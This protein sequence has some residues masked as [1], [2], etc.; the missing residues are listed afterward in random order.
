ML[1]EWCFKTCDSSTLF[2]FSQYFCK[3]APIQMSCCL[4]FFL[5]NFS[6]LLL[7]E[8]ANSWNDLN[9]R[10][11]GGWTCFVMFPVF[12]LIDLYPNYFFLSSS[13][14]F[15]LVRLHQL[16]IT[17]CHT[18]LVTMWFIHWLTGEKTTLQVSG[19][20]VNIL[21]SSVR[22]WSAQST[23]NIVKFQLEVIFMLNSI[24]WAS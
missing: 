16:P 19:I 17:H 1:Y 20:K 5:L 9:E 24:I 21:A 10:T 4:F 18:L 12:R 15:C 2:K 11:G 6:S 13:L 14:I 8:E 3:W 23:K 22:K 7:M